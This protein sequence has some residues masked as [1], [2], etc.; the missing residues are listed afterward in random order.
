MLRRR[1]AQDQLLSV[2]NL[3]HH[4]ESLPRRHHDHHRLRG[5]ALLVVVAVDLL[6]PRLPRHGD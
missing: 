3:H 5:L 1:H 2:R 4:D 6:L